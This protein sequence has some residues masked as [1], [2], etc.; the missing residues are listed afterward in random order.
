MSASAV[1]PTTRSMLTRSSTVPSWRSSCAHCYSV[2]HPALSTGY[3][4]D[5]QAF[6][7]TG[8]SIA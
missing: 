4:T 5:P 8:D 1:R 2:E 6:R 7:N 3:A